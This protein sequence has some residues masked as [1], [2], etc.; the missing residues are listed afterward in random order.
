MSLIERQGHFCYESNRSRCR[1]LV[2]PGRHIMK[3]LQ[4]AC[5][6]IVDKG[7]VLA[8]QRSQSMSLP[9]KWEFPGGKIRD[10]EHPDECLRRELLEE[11]GI[12]VVIES[13]LHLTT[14]HYPTV[15]VTLHPFLCSIAKGKITLHDMRPAAGFD[16]MN[17][18][19]KIGR[20]Q[21]GLW[22]RVAGMGLV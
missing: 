6:V 21:T 12:E 14:H 13:P 10:G 9:L 16:L 15:I 20:T 11:L 3:H 7:K 4:V 5:A 19:F 17:C 1:Q 18:R 22:S 8:T 2:V